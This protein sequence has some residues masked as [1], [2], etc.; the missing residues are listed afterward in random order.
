[1]ITPC[2]FA[3]LIRV[4]RSLNLSAENA[5]DLIAL[6]RMMGFTEQ[7]P[8]SKAKKKPLT[9]QRRRNN[10]ASGSDGGEQPAD[11]N[12]AKP[13][14]KK[15]ATTERAQKDKTQK[16]LPAVLQSDKSR[17]IGPPAWLGPEIQGQ[18]DTEGMNKAD[19]GKP[20]APLFRQ[21]RARALL[22]E[23]CSNLADSGKLNVRST[24]RDIALGKPITKPIPVFYRRLRSKVYVLMDVSETMQPFAHDMQILIK[25]LLGLLGESRVAFFDFLYCPNRGV[26]PA[27]L[28]DWAAFDWPEAGS[29]LVVISSLG[30]EINPFIIPPTPIEWMEFGE[31]A[32]KFKCPVVILNPYHPKRWPNYSHTVGRNIHWDLTTTVNSIRSSVRLKRVKNR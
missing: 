1:M 20:Y 14:P 26:R 31:N 13:P 3:D 29:L 10:N 16:A 30:V 8:D 11:S 12:I 23:L 19:L 4:A 18:T 22:T 7:E 9:E 24:V 17:P 15:T 2:S 25:Q 28:S 6:R 32:A 21:E 5:D 27:G